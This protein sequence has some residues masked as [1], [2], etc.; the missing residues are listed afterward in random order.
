MLGFNLILQIPCFVIVWNTVI[1]YNIYKMNRLF[2]SHIYLTVELM[3][4]LPLFLE[5]SR[6]RFFCSALESAIFEIVLVFSDV[7][8]KPIHSLLPSSHSEYGTVNL[9]LIYYFKT[10]YCF[11]KTGL[12]NLFHLLNYAPD[13]F[14]VVSLKFEIQAS[15]TIFHT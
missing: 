12:T 7:F 8:R 5:V 14:L 4:S 13:Y 10:S 9:R 15:K 1:Y 6:K 11:P 3:T 2:W